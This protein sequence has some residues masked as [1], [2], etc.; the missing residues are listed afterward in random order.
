MPTSQRTHP[1]GREP[2]ADPRETITPESF[3]IAPDLLG[4][5]LAGPWRRLG[6]MLVDLA[7][8]GLLSRAGAYFLAL[9]AAFVLW[10]AMG[11]RRDGV[12]RS[13]TRLWLRSIAALVVFITAIAT[14][15]NIRGLFHG[16]RSSRQDADAEGGGGIGV[17]AAAGP[18]FLSLRNAATQE[19]ARAAADRLV[20]T[21]GE[22]EEVDDA[23]LAD[24]REELADMPDSLPIL[25]LD[26]MKIRALRD[27][28][29]SHTGAAHA[30]PDV[31]SLSFA[32]AEARAQND[33]FR[34]AE[35]TQRMRATM[36]SDSIARLRG[37]LARAERENRSLQ[38][39]VDDRSFLDTLKDWADE[40]G[41]G[42]GWLG[43]YFTA[44]LALWNGQ[45]PGKRL[46]GMRVLRLDGKDIGWWAAFERFGGYA[47]GLV[48]GL[49]GFAQIFWDRNRQ[50]IHD[51]I[52]E[53]VVV[54]V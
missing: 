11:R 43:L 2:G 15:S 49:L 3:A 13:W 47:A 51:K 54:R 27:A 19:E 32:A 21:L 48:T 1:H 36:E 39:A 34:A 50:A 31:D 9:G 4:L 25:G 7:L 18:E 26:P 12:L 10:R 40:L 38:A 33:S 44:F 45:T 14:I 29:A 28:L 37:R 22:R 6:A 16:D 52:S 42:F 8:A 17:I 24:A 5:P 53:T 23:E 35:L 30:A 46:F 41:L 20:A